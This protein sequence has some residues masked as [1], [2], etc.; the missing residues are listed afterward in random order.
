MRCWRSRRF[1]MTPTVMCSARARSRGSAGGREDLE[2]LSAPLSQWGRRL[3]SSSRRA[4]SRGLVMGLGALWGNRGGGSR[5]GLSIGVRLRR[6]LWAGELGGAGGEKLFEAFVAAKRK[7]AHVGF[8]AAF[9][10]IG[11]AEDVGDDA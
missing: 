4:W 11:I 2:Y 7:E 6:R 3:E 5:R 1:L 10:R 8:E 9:V